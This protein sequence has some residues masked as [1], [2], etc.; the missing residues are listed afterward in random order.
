M[1]HVNSV[2]H[3][4]AR[5]E[6]SIQ[7]AIICEHRPLTQLSQKM[8]LLYPPW[9]GLLSPPREVFLS[10]GNSIN[11]SLL[12]AL[13]GHIASKKHFPAPV[14]IKVSA[15]PSPDPAVNREMHYPVTG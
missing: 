15:E 5:D 12:K 4:K 8:L 9:E 14:L 3:L 2:Q 10:L 13:K 11:Y 7:R 6:G 1:L